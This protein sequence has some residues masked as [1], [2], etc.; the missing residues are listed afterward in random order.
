I[1]PSGRGKDETAVCVLK[2]L[3]GNIY[4]RRNLGYREGYSDATLSN[5]VD[6]AKQERVNLILIES[7]FGDGMFQALLQPY[8]A[9]HYPCTCE[10]F[11]S[12][13]QKEKRII[14]TLE[15]VIEQ[16]RLIIDPQTVKDD[17][18]TTQGLPPE[19]ALSYRL[20]YQMTRISRLKGSLR[21]D[22]RIDALA[23][24]VGWFVEQMK[25]DQDKMED[26]RK[27]KTFKEE[28][29][30]FYS[31]GKRSCLT[32][33]VIQGLIPATVISNL[34]LRKRRKIQRSWRQM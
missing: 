18:D 13:T 21:H 11:R 23:A 34:P 19:D 7:N 31:N 3:N 6:I 15:P 17:L 1:D 22:D 30:V 28:L 9:K 27:D 20:F 10:E 32:K 14:D 16:H 29:D 25:Q 26:K 12:T 4:L 2:S 33:N 5:I 24:G 8:L